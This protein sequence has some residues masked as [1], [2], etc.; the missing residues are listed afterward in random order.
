VKR[1]RLVYPPEDSGVGGPRGAAKAALDAWIEYK[2][3]DELR[4]CRDKV[5]QLDKGEFDLETLIKPLKEPV[6]VTNDEVKLMLAK[7]SSTLGLTRT[8]GGKFRKL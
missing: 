5:I 4:Q 7:E 6:L 3:H 1:L 8:S 2:K